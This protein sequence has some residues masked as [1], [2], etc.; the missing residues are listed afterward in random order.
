PAGS[1]NNAQQTS[2][3]VRRI[4]AHCTPALDEIRRLVSETRTEAASRTPIADGPQALRDRVASFGDRAQI[5]IDVGAIDDEAVWPVH[6]RV[7]VEALTNVRRHA[8]PDA[9]VT[10]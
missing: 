7:L 4:E 2:T 3:A 5:A 10:V 6:D 1:S 8:G 9:P